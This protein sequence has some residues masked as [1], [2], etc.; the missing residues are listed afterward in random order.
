MCIDEWT[1]S[2]SFFLMA[3]FSC[4]KVVIAYMFFFLSSISPLHSF[5]SKVI[6]QISIARVSIDFC[7]SFVM[8]LV[9]TVKF[10]NILL[11][12]TMNAKM[13][14]SRSSRSLPLLLLQS[15]FL[16]FVV[17]DVMGK[18]L[19]S[20]REGVHVKDILTQ[21]SLDVIISNKCY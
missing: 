3:S 20:R 19:E 15:R 9:D 18:H 7:L 16:G 13:F 17:Q 8:F 14:L 4:L 6:C 10:F 21:V 5:I 1:P 11:D 12:R 2:T